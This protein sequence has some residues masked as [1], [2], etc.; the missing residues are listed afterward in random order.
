M[1]TGIETAI[2]VEDE[3]EI[4][5]LI[6]FHLEQMKLRVQIAGSGRRGLVLIKAAPP[7]V[8]LLDLML[9]DLSGLQVCQRVRAATETAATPIIMVTAKG[10][11]ADIVAGLEAGA[12]DYVTK[13]FSPRVLVARVR[14]ALRRVKR[15]SDPGV[16]ADRLS[17]Y[18]SRLCIDLG[19]HLVT[20]DGKPTDLTI[21]EFQLLHYLACRPGFVRTRD[22]IIAAVHGR[23][24]ILSSRTVDVHI[25]AIRRK[26]GDIGPS[27]ETVRGVG[28]RFSEVGEREPSFATD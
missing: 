8:I 2:V 19:R 13:P 21:T 20:V 24:T 25:T 23:N 22:Q 3:P 15:E 9:P 28:Y 1:T 7:T 27:I 6:R 26:L 14:A 4:A 11:E 18:D 5:E 16:R 10:S 12:D 17:L